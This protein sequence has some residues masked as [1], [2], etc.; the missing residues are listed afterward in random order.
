MQVKLLCAGNKVTRK[1]WLMANMP[2]E[3]KNW[4]FFAPCPDFMGGHAEFNV[5]LLNCAL[6]LAIT[7]I[8]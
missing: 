5:E 3:A 4:P 2:N 1:Y 8:L 7:H 6:S